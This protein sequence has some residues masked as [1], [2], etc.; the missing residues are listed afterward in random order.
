MDGMAGFYVLVLV[1]IG[2]LGNGTKL[3]VEKTKLCVK[4]RLNVKVNSSDK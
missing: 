2:Q 4:K 1:M 3:F